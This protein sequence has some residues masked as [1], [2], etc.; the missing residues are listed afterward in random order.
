MGSSSAS[1]PRIARLAVTLLTVCVGAALSAGPAHAQPAPVSTITVKKR[2]K[3]IPNSRTTKKARSTRARTTAPRTAPRPAAPSPAS[4]ARALVA[5]PAPAAAPGLPRAAPPQPDLTAP[6]VVDSSPK[7]LPWITLAGSVAAGVA[8][9]VFMSRAI[10]ALNEDIQVDLK[11]TNTG[12]VEIPQQIED[13]Q[14]R[15]LTNGVAGTA[16]LTAALTGTIA[17]LIALN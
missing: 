2:A 15:V 13:Q 8:G 1:R 6:A 16:L 3:L 4:Q 5:R 12:V 7:V 14:R 17:S 9:A 10:S 11:T